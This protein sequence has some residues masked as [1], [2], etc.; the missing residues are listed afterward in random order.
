[1]EKFPV[2]EW[3][4]A[5]NALKRAEEMCG[6]G[7]SYFLGN[8]VEA[9]IGFLEHLPRHVESGLLFKLGIG[10]AVASESSLQGADWHIEC[11]GDIG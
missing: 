11:S 7:V 1:M 3:G 9:H 5:G 10:H 6:V 2:L 4:D 8:V